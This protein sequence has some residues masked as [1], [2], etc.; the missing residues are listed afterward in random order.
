LNGLKKANEL[1]E[2]DRELMQKRSMDLNI[3]YDNASLQL[4]DL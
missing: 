1:N 2:K 4:S 3:K